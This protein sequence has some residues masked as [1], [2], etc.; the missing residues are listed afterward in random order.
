[1]IGNSRIWRTVFLIC[2]VVLAIS[3]ISLVTSNYPV[4]G[5][6]TPMIITDKEVYRWGEIIHVQYIFMNER[7]RAIYFQPP[8]TLMG[9]NGRFEGDLEPAEAS[10]V[11]HISYT[12]ERIT[13]SPGGFFTVLQRD[14]PQKRVGNFTVWCGS[15]SK[16]VEVL[17]SD[18]NQIK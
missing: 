18:P 14:F 12:S 7:N 15:V 13:L 11:V 6:P 3:V 8:G 4:E 9:I 2:F 16:T 10:S 5:I 1:M 17:A